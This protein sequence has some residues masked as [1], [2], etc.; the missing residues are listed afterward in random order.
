M[1]SRF[2]T[3]FFRN[4][5][6]FFSLFLH[7][8]DNQSAPP[9]LCLAQLAPAVLQATLIEKNKLVRSTVR[10]QAPRSTTFQVPARCG[11][12]GK[13]QAKTFSTISD[14]RMRCFLIEHARLVLVVTVSRRPISSVRL[15]FSHPTIRVP[16]SVDAHV[17]LRRGLCARVRHGGCV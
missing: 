9:P 12:D 15:S 6:W 8:Q 16:S 14:S 3:V 2:F 4:T 1:L 13:A 11:Y 5:R 10:G 7:A 17:C